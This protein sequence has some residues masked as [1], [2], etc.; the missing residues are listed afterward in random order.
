MLYTVTTRWMREPSEQHKLLLATMLCERNNY[1]WTGRPGSAYGCE[2]VW[3][4]ELYWIRD[5]ELMLVDTLLS[6]YY[7]DKL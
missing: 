1:T 3:E 5:T 6:E 4:L 7:I 2:L